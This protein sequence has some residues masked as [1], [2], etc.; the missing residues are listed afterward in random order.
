[1]DIDDDDEL[2]LK[3]NDGREGLLR[4]RPEARREGHGCTDGIQ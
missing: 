4:C 3:Q 1:M 2:M